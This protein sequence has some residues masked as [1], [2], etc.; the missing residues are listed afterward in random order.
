[1]KIPKSKELLPWATLTTGNGT[2]RQSNME[3]LRIIAMLMVLIAHADY[4]SIGIPLCDDISTAPISSFFRIVIEVICLICVNLF[5]LISGY[6]GIKWN[7]KGIAN[8]L[9]QIYFWNIIIYLI[10]HCIGIIDITG[11]KTNFIFAMKNWWFVEAY[12]AL[13]L[14]SPL[15]NRFTADW[16]QK[17]ARQYLLISWGIIF[18]GWLVPNFLYISQ[19]SIILFINIYLTGKYIAQFDINFKLR[20]RNYYLLAYITISVL[21]ALFILI[22]TTHLPENQ[23]IRRS[24]IYMLLC[25]FPVSVFGAICLFL[26]FKDLHINNKYIN[27]IAASTFAVYLIHCHPRLICYYMD[28]SNYIYKHFDTLPYILLISLFIIATFCLCVLLDQ[29]RIFAW[30]LLTYYVGTRKKV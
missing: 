4:L 30:N 6:F 21:T 11:Y 3:L 1:M 22:S 13:W 20:N 10:L 12:L 17:Q 5:V 23:L 9:F 18:I 14:V 26:Y 28:A 2:T 24:N 29:I 7:L 25:N 16:T 15:L 8:L 27:Y 19:E